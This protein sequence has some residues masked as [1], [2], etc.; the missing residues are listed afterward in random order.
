MEG[1]PVFAGY[2]KSRPKEAGFLGKKRKSL[3]LNDQTQGALTGF[4]LN[5]DHVDTGL[6]RTYLEGKLFLARTLAQYR[7]TERVEDRHGF[8]SIHRKFQRS[9]GARRV[10]V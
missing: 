1:Y 7:L 4:A 10:G 5:A 9:Y 6:Q 2:K 3:V 8:T